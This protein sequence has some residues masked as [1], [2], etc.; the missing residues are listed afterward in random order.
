MIYPL[1]SRA[2]STVIDTTFP[3]GQQER[4]AQAILDPLNEHALT[5]LRAEVR[6]GYNSGTSRFLCPACRG[7][8]FVAQNPAKPGVPTDGRSAHFKHHAGKDAPDCDLRTETNLRAIGAVKF[9]GLAEG[10]DHAALKQQL[11]LAL[12]Q[13]PDIT[14]IRIEQ[15]IRSSD[16]NWCQPDVQAMIGGRLVAFDLQLAAA[17]LPTI[18]SRAAFYLANGVCHV[19]LTD[20]M[21]LSRLSQLAFRDLYLS[22]GGRIFAIDAE[23]V[24]GCVEN[25][26]F[27]LKELSL[28]PRFVPSLPLH[29]TWDLA[30]VDKAVITMNPL[31]RKA[32]GEK[33]YC[34]TL[35]AQI[36]PVFGPDRGIIRQ[37]ASQ[38]RNLGWVAPQWFHISSQICGPST[39][40]AGNDHI[41]EVLAWL[42][43]VE[44]YIKG[45]DIVHRAVFLQSLQVA[46]ER[47]LTVQNAHD[48]A[49]LVELT[50]KRLAWLQPLLSPENH[51]LLHSLLATTKMVKPMVRKYAGMLAVLY[52]WISFRLIVKP[53]KFGP[54]RF[55]GQRAAS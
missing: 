3:A 18:V 42:F 25:A 2:I 30:I 52:P 14:D 54:S 35:L 1:K 13:D 33:R 40:D 19:W 32:E 6:A 47:L 55:R 34:T 24:A 46:T 28:S 17:S 45:D 10:M 53:P 23:V 39:Y 5:A 4:Q 11:A 41:S 16:G 12:S 31:T 49:P 44:A 50:C 36:T 29:N 21:N 48:W 15:Q 51:A 37:A 7:P 22:T 9:A 26:T 27:Q 8:M 43:A 38:R 20:A